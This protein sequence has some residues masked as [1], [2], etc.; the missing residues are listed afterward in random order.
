M[1]NC[2]TIGQQLDARALRRRAPASPA[3]GDRCRCRRRARASLA[4]HCSRNQPPPESVPLSTAIPYDAAPESTICCEYC[5]T[6]SSDRGGVV[7]VE[8]G[9]LEDVLVV[10]QHRVADA[11]WHAALH[12]ARRVRGQRRGL[13]RAGVVARRLEARPDRD[14]RVGV[15]RSAA[16]RTPGRSRRRDG[17]TGSTARTCRSSAS[18][19]PGSGARRAPSTGKRCRR[20]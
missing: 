18:S 9:S 6:S 13:E 16:R 3:P 2:C 15:G 14:D 8:A 4:N 11:E 7:G 1:I 5:R 19:C 10:V 12:A 20:R 17:S